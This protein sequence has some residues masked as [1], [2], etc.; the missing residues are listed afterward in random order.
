M[1]ARQ[2]LAPRA[3][4][5]LPPL[6]VDPRPFK[7][8]KQLLLRMGNDI[9][10]FLTQTGFIFPPK[11]SG[12]FQMPSQALFMSA[13][14]HIYLQCIDLEYDFGDK[15]KKDGKPPKT[16]A[17]KIEEVLQ[18]LTDIKYPQ[19]ADVHKTKLTTAGSSF[20]WPPVCAMLHWMICLK[21]SN[22]ASSGEV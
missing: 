13:F 14:R 22:S 17:E 18:I 15:P 4:G 21:V 8:N 2:S 20:G 6:P 7:E 9:Q 19:L 11:Y 10:D 3:G 1:A 5:N 12:V 16:E